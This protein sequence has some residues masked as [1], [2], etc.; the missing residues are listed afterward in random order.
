MKILLLDEKIQPAT[1]LELLLRLHGNRV[2]RRSEA[3]IAINLY[4]L[5]RTTDRA[6]DV[7]IVVGREHQKRW[8]KS[9]TPEPLCQMILLRTDRDCP[10]RYCTEAGVLQVCTDRALKLIL[11]GCSNASAA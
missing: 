4:R 11:N 9:Y 5:Y 6:F 2:E 7:V 8:K 3:D 10:K 1:E